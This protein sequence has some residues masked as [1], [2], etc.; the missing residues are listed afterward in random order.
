MPALSERRPV[1]RRVAQLSQRIRFF[2]MTTD[3]EPGRLQRAL[4]FYELLSGQ[5]NAATFKSEKRINLRI[6]PTR[7]DCSMAFL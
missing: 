4:G 5:V 2:R 6:S 1:H 3:L 7:S